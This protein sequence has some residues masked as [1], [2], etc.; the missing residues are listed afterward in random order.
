MKPKGRL[1]PLLCAVAAV[2]LALP[3]TASAQAD[4]EVHPG[5]FRLEIELPESDGWQ[6]S[7]VAYDHHQIYLKTQRGFASV[8]YRAPGRVSTQKVEADFGALGRI[9][10]DLSLKA[11]GT[12]VPRLHGRC[13]GRSPYDLVGRFHGMV[14]F[15]GEPNIVGVSARSGQAKIMRSFQHVCQPLTPNSRKKNPLDLGVE[16]FGARSHEEGRTTSF[17]AVGI[18]IEGALLLGVAAGTLYERAG[19][20]GIARTRAAL[21]FENELHFSKPGA[22]PE[23]VRVDPAKPFL[24]SAAY[25]KQKGAAPRWSGDL[26]VAVP[27]GGTI[28]L[29]GP[30]FSGLLCHPQSSL[31]LTQCVPQLQELKRVAPDSLLRPY[32]RVLQR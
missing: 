7:L 18:T 32:R 16:L 15:P 14:D 23:R 25:L 21:V 1:L 24:G 9:D 28:S 20:V 6:I 31:D 2:L 26:T 30:T 27:G 19:E 3:A 5:R 13:T 8:T 11:R 10:L 4:D 22:Q 12:G 29:A 17:Q